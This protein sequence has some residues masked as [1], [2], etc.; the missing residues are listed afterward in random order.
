MVRKQQTFRYV[1]V[2]GSFRACVGVL[3]LVWVSKF[4]TV[5]GSAVHSNLHALVKCNP[6][7]QRPTGVGQHSSEAEVI[8]HTLPIYKYTG[9]TLSTDKTSEVFSYLFL[10]HLLTLQNCDIMSSI[11][12][13][14]PV[15]VAEYWY[16]WLMMCY[17]WTWSFPVVGMTKQQGAVIVNIAKFVPPYVYWDDQNM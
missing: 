9:C 16:F 5:P 17:L 4:T 1:C 11:F 10:L 12:N 15:Y 6:L 2:C 7:N 14:H 8:F 3:G 13:R